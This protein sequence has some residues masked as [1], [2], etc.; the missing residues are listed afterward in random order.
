MHDDQRSVSHLLETLNDI[1]IIGAKANKWMFSLTTR[2]C[3]VTQ[4]RPKSISDQPDLI[5]DTADAQQ[6]LISLEVYDENFGNSSCT[7]LGEVLGKYNVI[8]QL[9]LGKNKISAKGLSRLTESLEKNKS[10]EKLNLRLNPLENEGVEVL[11]RS[12]ELNHSLTELVL[13]HTN[14]QVSSMHPSFLPT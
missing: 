11:S 10:L 7:A 12:L 1:F 13:C 5:G 8:S 9:N 6:P 3:T 2:H 4:T 14:I